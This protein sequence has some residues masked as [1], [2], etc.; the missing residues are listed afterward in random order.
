MRLPVWTSFVFAT[1]SRFIIRRGA[2]L[3]K[4][5]LRSGSSVRIALTVSS[6]SPSSMRSPIFAPSAGA[7]RSSSQTVPGRGTP[8][9][10]A[11]GT[12]GPGAVRRLPRSG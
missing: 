5:T 4:L 9:A 6:V 3:K 10:R 8:S 11:S 1:S 7:S 2:M 12:F